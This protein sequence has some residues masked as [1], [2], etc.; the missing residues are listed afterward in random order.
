[1]YLEGLNKSPKQDADGVTLPKKFDETS[2][3]KKS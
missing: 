1:M 3:S 2:S